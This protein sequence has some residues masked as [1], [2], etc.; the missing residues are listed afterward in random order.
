MNT[1]LPET[2]MQ[3]KVAL[4][5]LARNWS[6]TRPPQPEVA[7]SGRDDCQRLASAREAR[8]SGERNQ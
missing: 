1:A 7:P 8:P 5:L 2:L 3:L 6:A 4:P